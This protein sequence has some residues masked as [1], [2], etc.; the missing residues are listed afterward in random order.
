M[1]IRDERLGRRWVQLSDVKVG[2]YVEHFL[3][4]AWD[5][6]IVDIDQKH[7][8][9]FIKR[10][11]ARSTWMNLDEIARINHQPPTPEHV[12]VY[13]RSAGQDVRYIMPFNTIS[14]VTCDHI[15][16]TD[17][18]CLACWDSGTLKNLKRLGVPT[19]DDAPAPVPDPVAV[20]TRYAVGEFVLAGDKPGRITQ[21]NGN[22]YRVNTFDGCGIGNWYAESALTDLPHRVGESVYHRTLNQSGEVIKPAF[23]GY[24]VK[25]GDDPRPRYWQL[26]HLVSSTSTFEP[27]RMTQLRLL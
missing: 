25:L 12:I 19:H 8:K 3:F 14:H 6:V 24:L 20:T 10:D 15:C 17:G 16:T 7:L 26:A 21:I 1:A 27:G 23:R 22:Q 5:G 2:D 18:K 11:E 4:P 9:V 13:I